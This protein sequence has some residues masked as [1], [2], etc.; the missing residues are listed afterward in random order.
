MN[1]CLVLGVIHICVCQNVTN[2]TKMSKKGFLGSTVEFHMLLRAICQ[3][4]N[5]FNTVYLALLAHHFKGITVSG[6]MMGLENEVRQNARK[7]QQER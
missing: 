4:T 2:Q 1:E 3:L 6:E 7:G 5:P